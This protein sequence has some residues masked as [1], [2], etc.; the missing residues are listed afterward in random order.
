M[1]GEATGGVEGEGAWGVG[2]GGCLAS[3]GRL[4]GRMKACGG[5]LNHRLHGCILVTF[6]DDCVPAAP[7][8]CCSHSS[9]LHLVPPQT[10][11]VDEI[12]GAEAAKQVVEEAIQVRVGAGGALAGT[13]RGTG[14]W[15]QQGRLDGGSCTGGS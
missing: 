7:P 10:V 8:P 13:G 15:L 4:W 5:K 1:V 6:M 11:Q 14:G 2:E 3:W 12:K 9:S